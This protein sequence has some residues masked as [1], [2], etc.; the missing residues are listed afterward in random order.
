MQVQDVE[1]ELPPNP[2]RANPERRGAVAIS[3]NITATTGGPTCDICRLWPPTAARPLPR[4]LN[5]A[6]LDR[7]LLPPLLPLGPPST[8]AP[9]VS[10]SF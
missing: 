6:M 10:R 8:V 4:L 3:N 7:I 9:C 5:S 2:E 1:Q